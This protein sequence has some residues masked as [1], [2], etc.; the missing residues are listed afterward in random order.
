LAASHSCATRVRD[1]GGHSQ[2]GFRC[3]R[4]CSGRYC[5]AGTH[6]ARCTPVLHACLCQTAG[7]V[8][9]LKQMSKAH[10]IDNKLV[11]H[12]H[13]EKK[14]CRVPC[15]ACMRCAAV[16]HGVKVGQTL[17]LVTCRTCTSAV[18]VCLC[19][20]P[21]VQCMIDC[22]SPW[23]VNLAA[24]GKDERNVYMLLEAV[25][26]GE[27]F[28]YL[29]VNAAACVVRGH[30]EF[31]ACLPA[32]PAPDTCSPPT[33]C[34]AAPRRHADDSPPPPHTHPPHTHTFTTRR[35]AAR[36]CPS[37]TRASTWPP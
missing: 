17:K 29:Q 23:L 6:A 22:C 26:G 34:A 31:G 28:A 20:L 3:S 4:A 27:L 9:A 1:V 8:Y 37:R 21:V 14:V 19:A 36:R 35:R 12:V 5:G 33:C 7:K 13:R 2:R 25:M 30:R 24:T 32:S 10:I 16:C 18:C 11:A 15:K